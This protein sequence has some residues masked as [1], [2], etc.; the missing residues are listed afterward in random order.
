MTQQRIVVPLN[1]LRAFEA[2]GRHMSFVSAA[3]ELYVTA[4]AISHHVKYLEEVLG[5][6]LFMRGHRSLQI[7]EAGRSCLADLTGGFL[8][9]EGAVSR[10]KAAHRDGPLR[11]RVPAC[12]AS[13][14]LMPR[15]TAFQSHHP[16]IEL[17]ISVSSQIY[18]FNFGEMDALLRLRAGD[19]NAMRTERFLTETIFP[20]CSPAFLDSH[21]PIRSPADLLNLPILHDD[22]LSVI[23]T[24][25]SWGKWLDFSGVEVTEPLTGHRFDSSSMVIDATVDGRGVSLGRSALVEHE[26]KLGRLVRLFDHDYP[27]TH[28]Y[29]MIYP[30]T[31][32]RAR[33]IQVLLDWLRAEAG[34]SAPALRR[35]AG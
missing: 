21:G 24:V 6:P 31:S 20:V 13:R 25:P 15:L 10:L 35:K 18:S 29:F 12:F 9:I 27:V 30:E 3:K 7:T 22:N 14:W 23:P 32:P 34:Q 16:D 17:E 28:D 1:A 26:L 5:T 19:F 4:A 8:A 2:A 33:Q 11:V